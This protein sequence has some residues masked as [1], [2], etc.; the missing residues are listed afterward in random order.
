MQRFRIRPF[1]WINYIFNEFLFWINN[2]LTKTCFKST[3]LSIWIRIS[4][5]EKLQLIWFAEMCKAAVW[6]CLIF[7]QYY[8][9]TKP[10]FLV[11]IYKLLFLVSIYQFIADSLYGGYFMNKE[12]K[13]NVYHFK[14]Q[15]TAE[16][17]SSVLTD[18][19]LKM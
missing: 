4:A 8:L 13:T 14:F 5:S 3:I 6:F 17:W 2:F 9:W 18:W 16:V 12:S 11:S 1:F 19:S 10:S 15:T 7:D